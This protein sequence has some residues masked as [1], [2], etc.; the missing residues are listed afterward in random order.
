[1][2]PQESQLPLGMTGVAVASEIL[3]ASTLLSISR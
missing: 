2:A 3:A 1:V